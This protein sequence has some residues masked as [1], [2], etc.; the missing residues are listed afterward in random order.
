MTRSPQL[1]QDW[2]SLV[3][4]WNAG[5]DPD[6]WL[7]TLGAMTLDRRD[8]TIRTG[9]PGHGH[10]FPEF[11]SARLI[12]NHRIAG[13]LGLGAAVLH[14]VRDVFTAEN[15]RLM[16]Q[17]WLIPAIAFGEWDRVV[18]TAPPPRTTETDRREI[19]GLLGCLLRMRVSGLRI[20]EAE[21]IVGLLLTLDDAPDPLTLAL[22]VCEHPKLL[23]HVPALA[24]AR[25]YRGSPAV[26]LMLYGA[27]ERV[28][29]GDRAQWQDLYHAV[30]S[31]VGAQ[32][33]RGRIDSR[34]AGL[35]MLQVAPGKDSPRR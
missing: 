18:V 34:E 12:G 32:P 27:Q 3:A 26:A 14:G 11:D 24:N 19:A 30:G 2:P 15:W 31:A 29:P 28:A 21:A 8:G 4:L 17:S 13:Q 16:M 7:A 10:N 20:S 22:A 23:V 5:L 35:L 1:T 33:D 9:P 6:A 25:L